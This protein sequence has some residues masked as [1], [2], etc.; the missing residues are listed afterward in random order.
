MSGRGTIPDEIRRFIVAAVPSV[1]YLEALLL[2]RANPELSW[3]PELLAK[4]LYIGMAQAEDIAEQL[5]GAGIIML[6]NPETPAFRYAPQD[7]DLP[8]LLALLEATYRNALVEVSQ[9]I[10]SKSGKR[11]QRFADAFKFRKD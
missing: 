7:P 9:L 10:H 4:R 5:Q 8:E 11:A 3:T 2:I 1:S 6:A